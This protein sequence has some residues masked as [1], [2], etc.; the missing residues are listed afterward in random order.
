MLPP[1]PRPTLRVKQNNLRRHLASYCWEASRHFTS[2]VLHNCSLAII[3]S[4]DSDLSGGTWVP[5]DHPLQDWT[6][7]RW[8]SQSLLAMPISLRQNLVTYTQEKVLQRARGSETVH[9]VTNQPAFR[10]Q[11]LLNPKGSHFQAILFSERILVGS[12]TQTKGAE[13]NGQRSR[14]LTLTWPRAQYSSS[15]FTFSAQWH[16]PQQLWN[17]KNKAARV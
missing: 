7:L 15:N 8:T 2:D 4:F 16:S 9:C 13:M 6:G 1:H 12:Q 5:E 10:K 11:L 17:V 14:I 3:A